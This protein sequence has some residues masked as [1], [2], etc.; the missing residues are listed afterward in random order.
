MKNKSRF[1]AAPYAVWML[2]F[3][4][5]PLGIV[6]FYAFTDAG[7]SFTLENITSIGSYFP[8]FLRS[9]WYSIAAALICLLIGYPVAYYIAQCKPTT[10]R[11]LYMLI[12][13]PMCMSFLLRTLAW[14]ALLD[15]T[16]I[17]NSLVTHFGL[18]PLPLTRNPF[19]VISGM[20]YNYLPYMI[21]PLYT[22]LMKLDRRLIEASQD[23]GC[24]PSQTFFRVILPLSVPGIVSGVTMV[25]VPAVSTFYIS[26]KLGSTST[27]MI[28]DIIESQYKTAYNPNLGAALSLVLMALIFICVGIMNRFTSSDE[29]EGMMTL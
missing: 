3:T 22:V 20:V 11:F 21:M 2:I 1:L 17:I 23:L 28:G 5:V 16:G 18:K 24:R 9:I 4:I 13:L 14:V 12:M 8:I 7:G 19:A 15:D 10:Q 26:Q 29:E 25:F 27:I 6:A